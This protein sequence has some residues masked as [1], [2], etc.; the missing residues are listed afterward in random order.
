MRLLIFGAAG[1]GKLVMIE[2]VFGQVTTT[3]PAST[4]I[5]NPLLVARND[6]MKVHFSDG[7]T[8]DTVNDVR[9]FI[10]KYQVERDIEKQLHAIWYVGS[11]TRVARRTPCLLTLSLCQ[12]LHRLNEGPAQR[13]GSVVLSSG[14]QSSWPLRRQTRLKLRSV[15]SSL[16]SNST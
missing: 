4:S 16:Q 7:V 11:F 2:S 9:F 6:L 12:V 13:F 5:D 15:Q 3:T 1:S 8:V 14:S 10:D